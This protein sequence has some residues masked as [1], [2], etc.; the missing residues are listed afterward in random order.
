M[1]NYEFPPIGGGA[2][3]AHLCLLKEFANNAELVIDVLTSSPSPG[4][5]QET[6][7]PN[8][9]VYK[10]GVHKKNLHFWRRVEIV[11]WLFKA[12]LHYRKLIKQSNYDLIHIF[13]G[14]PTGLLCLPRP[15][16]PYI[17]SLRGSDVPGEHARFAL[18]YKIFGLPLKKIWKNAAGL[19]ACSEG[20]K[21]R[22]LRFLSDAT[23]GVIPNGVELDIFRP[24]AELKSDNRWRLITVGRLSPTK[25]IDLLIDAVEL[26]KKQGQDV[27]LSI[28]GGGG[29]L[30]DA[31]QLVEQR[32]LSSF[33]S[34]LG[35]VPN[36]K[37]PDIY[38]EHDIFVSATMQEGMSNAMLEAMASGL[39]IVTTRCEGVDELIKDNGVIVENAG[40]A[41]LAAAIKNVIDNLDV[42]RQMRAAARLHAERFSWRSVAHQYL[43]CYRTVLQKLVL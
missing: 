43:V 41:D 14:I 22:G 31:Q 36:D 11:E 4:F 18:D 6:L 20:L 34:V 21:Q 42:Y 23:I 29:G 7:S 37:M 33:I 38:R 9:N 3:K 2:G 25:R 10:V 24:T 28:V 1:L 15:N 5:T 40:T 8:I 12:K 16:C 13:F 32:N 19:V 35:R 27:T 39:P 17:V 26:I 30:K